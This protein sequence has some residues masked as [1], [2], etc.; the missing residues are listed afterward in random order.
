VAITKVPSDMI[1]V[2]NNVTDTTVG[3]ANSAVSLTFD[4]LGVIS[5]ASNVALQIN[6][7]DIV[8]GAIT[9][10]KIADGTIIAAD[11]A[12]GSITTAKIADANVTSAKIAD[13]NVTSAKLAADLQFTS[14][15]TQFIGTGYSPTITLTDGATISWNTAEGQVAEVTLE[16]NRTMAA[17]TNVKDGAFYSLKVIQDGT[18]SRTISWNAV[19]KFTG[20]TAPTLSTAANSVDFIVFSSDGTNLYEQGRSLGV[21]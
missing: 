5:T 2:A 20:A 17:P 12:D 7:A 15:N 18:G 21:A 13:A 6:T 19:F 16:G 9:A 8:N 3:G 11:I 10:D 1:Q 14:G 4:S